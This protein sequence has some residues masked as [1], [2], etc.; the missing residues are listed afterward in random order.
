MTS[1]DYQKCLLIS[2]GHELTAASYIQ[3]LLYFNPPQVEAGGCVY[4]ET[5][6]HNYNLFW[7]KDERQTGCMNVH[8]LFVC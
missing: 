7:M 8:M 6:D 4:I 1:L 2:T 3:L 5:S